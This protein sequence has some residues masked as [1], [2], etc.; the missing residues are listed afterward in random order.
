MLSNALVLALA[1]FANDI[2]D[3]TPQDREIQGGNMNGS[4]GPP[5]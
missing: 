2:L 4:D 1:Y 3:K 5:C